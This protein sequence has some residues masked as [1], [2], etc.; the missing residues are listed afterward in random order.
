MC[1]FV[2]YSLD[3][4]VKLW[5]LRGSD[6]ALQ[7]WN[8]LPHGLAAF[9]VHPQT[10]VFATTSAVT[11]THWR[12]H[13]ITIH[14][15]TSSLSPSFSN[16]SNSHHTYAQTP[17]PLSSFNIPTGIS[18]F[19]STSARGGMPSPYI[20]RSTSMVFHPLEMLFG[21]GGPDGTGEFFCSFVH[22]LLADVRL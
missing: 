9:D 5:D 15:L 13:R 2:P 16:H 3:G 8:P 19:S 1:L 4:E 20:P 10:G 22:L 11:P 7:T 14:S 6:K 17:L 21:V 18:S 12:D